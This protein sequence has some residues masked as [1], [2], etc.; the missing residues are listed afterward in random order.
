[1]RRQHA[2]RVVAELVAAIGGLA[3]PDRQDDPGWHAVLLLDRGERRAV[4][5]VE[6]AALRGEVRKRPLAHV[7][8]RRLHEFRL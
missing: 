2:D 3:P 4:L 5:I 1:L 8:G 6:L 7:V